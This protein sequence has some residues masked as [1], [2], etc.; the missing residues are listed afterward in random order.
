MITRQS[1]VAVQGVQDTAFEPIRIRQ[2]RETSELAWIGVARVSARRCDK[3]RLCWVEHAPLSDCRA[4]LRQ[5]AQC[6]PGKN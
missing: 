2:Q 3:Y 5:A 1:E 4:Q 6:L